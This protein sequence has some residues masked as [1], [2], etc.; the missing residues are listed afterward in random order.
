MAVCLARVHWGEFFAA[1]SL[2]H[3][4]VWVTL[5]SV[6]LVRDLLTRPEDARRLVKGSLFERREVLSCCP[7]RRY[8]FA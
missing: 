8:L 1:R 2:L 4:G 5:F 7:F 6:E 3:G